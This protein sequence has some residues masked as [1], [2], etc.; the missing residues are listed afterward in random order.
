[1]FIASCVSPTRYLLLRFP[2]PFFNEIRVVVVVDA[3]TTAA[4]HDALIKAH[5]NAGTR[6]TVELQLRPASRSFPFNE[7]LGATAVTYCL[8]CISSSSPPPP[9]P[10]FLAETHTCS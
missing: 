5:C 10:P 4:S 8:F 7:R 6:S 1:M 2:F 9:P 3:A